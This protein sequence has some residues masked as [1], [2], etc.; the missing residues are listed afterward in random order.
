MPVHMKPRVGTRVKAISPLLPEGGELL[1]VGVD[2]HRRSFA[3]AIWSDQ[4]GQVAQWTQP[5]E[6]AVL[7]ARL[8][9][10]QAQVGGVVYEAGPTGFGLVRALQAA[11]F[12]ADVIATSLMLTTATRSAKSDRLD[13]RRLAEHAGKKL[14]RFIRVPTEEEE[15]DRQMMRLREQMV[16]KHR[17]VRQQIKSFLL[18]HS[19]VYPSGLKAWT[20]QGL[21]VLRELAMPD[22]LRRC[23]DVLMDEEEHARE[24]VER[25]NQ[26]IAA[27]MATVRHQKKV[28][29]LR[30]VPG[31]GV[32][33]AMTFQTELLGPERFK[34]PGEV[35]KMI[36]LAPLV[37]QSGERRQEGR[38]MKLGNRRLRTILVEAA[39]RWVQKDEGAKA[40]CKRLIRNT[41][42]IKK[43]IVAVARRLAIM[44]W[45]MVTREEMY[46]GRLAT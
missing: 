29:I 14:L 13:C 39:W 21:K 7:V 17:M 15:H 12:K 3:V 26:A 8:T 41:G 31:V 43:A 19:I 18:T 34:E 37:Q 35:A 6:P 1:Y 23:F 5:S 33:T 27:L 36:G 30:S 20:Q 25:V 4:R 45:R 46:R 22:A 38:L 11:G 2:V 10:L 40:L 16:R 32:V 28:Q 9:P 44:L 42:D 24:Q